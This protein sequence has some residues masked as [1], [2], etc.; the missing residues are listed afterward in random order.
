M[1]G[2]ASRVKRDIDRW[3]QSGLL[4]ASI[5]AR[6]ARD[7]DENHRAV[8]FGAVLSTM[9]AVLFA[10]AILL[11]VAANWEDLPRLARVGLLF[12]LIVGG[13]VGGAAFKMWG[14]DVLGEC[15][16]VIAATAFGASTALIAQMYHL[17]GDET[18]AIL[19]WCLA[20]SLASALLLSRYLNVGAVLLAAAWYLV[21]A[22]ESELPGSE[23]TLAALAIVGGLYF[24]TFWTKSAPARHLAVLSISFI[25]LIHFAWDERSVTSFLLGAFAVALFA[26]GA[27]NQRAAGRTTGLGNAVLLHGLIAFL[28]AVGMQ[29]LI[30]VDEDGFLLVTIFAFVGI[31]AALVLGGRQSTLLRWFAYAA[32]IFQLCFLYLVLLGSMLDTA[33]FFIVGGLVLSVL[34][35]TIGRLEKRFAKTRKGGAA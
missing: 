34:A 31:I 14:R 26:Y 20:T 23:V 8:S 22:S 21:S 18:Q 16:F 12:A 35:F 7:I 25:A 15:A 6:L 24:L 30:L 27:V 17:S 13:Y 9:A 32:F 4:D 11:I 3:R 10:A 33:G 28:A 1:S 2:Y 19:V 29:Q 5:A